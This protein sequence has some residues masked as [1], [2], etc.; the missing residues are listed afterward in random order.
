MYNVCTKN[1]LL[2]FMKKGDKKKL[3][4]FLIFTKYMFIIYQNQESY[5]QREKKRNKKKT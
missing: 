3:S 1:C 2:Y 4:T 5:V